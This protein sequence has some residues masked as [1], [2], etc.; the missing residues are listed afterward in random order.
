MCEQRGVHVVVG[1]PYNS[2]LLAGGRNFDYQEASPEM[3]ARRDRIAVI[4]AR[5]GAD[6]RSA[7]LQ[8]C[9]AHPVVA[10][11]IPGAKHARKVQDNARLMAAT[12]PAAVW[13]ELR[14]EGLIPE[15]APTP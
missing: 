10:A 11:I 8:F 6:I 13:K 14:R 15:N 5:H 3:V 7:A 12:V 9:A 1:G 2:G 4:C